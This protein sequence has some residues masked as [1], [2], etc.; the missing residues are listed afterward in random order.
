MSPKKILVSIILFISSLPGATGQHVFAQENKEVA[1]AGEIRQI[2]GYGPPG[3]GEDKKH[4]VRITYWVL[5][6]A[7]PVN[8]PCTPE[9]PKWAAEDCKG[10]KQLRLFFPTFPAN[11]GLESKAS[12]IQGRH[13]VVT[14]ILHRSDTVG[15]I[16]PL[17]MNA[18][19]VQLAPESVQH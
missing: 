17:Y 3:Y 10:S 12:K 15:E 14:G 2:H 18:I 6:L 11:N 8:L 1:L 7:Q 16:T 19:D 9:K 4:D 13:A 5:D